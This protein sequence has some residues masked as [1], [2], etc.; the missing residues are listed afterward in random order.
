MANW[1]SMPG[2][3]IVSDHD[4]PVV[5]EYHANGAIVK[6]KHGASFPCKGVFHA[7]VP[8]APNG[9]PKA[10]HVCIKH[11]HILSKTCCAE[12]FHGSNMLYRGA[13][14][15]PHENFDIAD[16]NVNIDAEGEH[17]GWGVSISVEFS[18]SS[19]ILLVSAITMQFQ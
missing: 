6:P 13:P 2:N 5:I 19:S 15:A 7:Y 10:K 11:T 9:S 8:S 1:I 14:K 4:C 3:C 12:V 16:M 18:G 17:L